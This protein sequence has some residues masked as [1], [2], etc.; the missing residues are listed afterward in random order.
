MENIS[1][2]P[3]VKNFLQNQV[4]NGIYKTLSD[5]INANIGMIIV[6][7]SIARKQKEIMNAEIQK[8]LD[9]VKAGRVSDALT[10]MDE[11]ISKYEK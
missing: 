2:S 6:Q 10:F 11:L 5:A 3:D 1:L 8:G 4:A 9:D 7:T